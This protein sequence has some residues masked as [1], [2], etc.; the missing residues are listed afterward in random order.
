MEAEVD[1]PRLCWNC[2]QTSRKIETLVS[3]SVDGCGSRDI[4]IGVSHPITDDQAMARIA[5]GGWD[6]RHQRYDEMEDASQEGQERWCALR[7]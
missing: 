7:E 4:R 1:V 3:C 6:I 5:G 2:Y